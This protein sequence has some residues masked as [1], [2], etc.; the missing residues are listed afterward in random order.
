VHQNNS[1]HKKKK[2][3]IKKILI[4]FLKYN[5]HRVANIL[6]IKELKPGMKKITKQLRK[7]IKKSK[8]N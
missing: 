7:I 4:F 5:L 2:N 6:R 3:F 1:K 8:N